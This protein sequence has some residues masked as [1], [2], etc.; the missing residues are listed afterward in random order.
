MNNQMGLKECAKS[1]WEKGIAAIMTGWGLVCRDR[2]VR[3]V[4]RKARREEKK[5]QQNS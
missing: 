3:K 4:S 5:A 1:D 2:Q